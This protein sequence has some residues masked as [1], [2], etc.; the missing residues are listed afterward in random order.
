MTP[1]TA[2]AGLAHEPYVLL[3][4]FGR[5]ARA[6]PTPVWIAGFDDRLVVSTPEGA[7]NLRACSRRAPRL[8][9]GVR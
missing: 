4:T 1:G 8:P 5:D 9:L 2:L 7:G 3:M 6:A